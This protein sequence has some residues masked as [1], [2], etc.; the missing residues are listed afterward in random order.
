MRTPEFI[1]RCMDAGIP[2]DM[3]LTAAKAFEAECE[4]AVGEVMEARRAK[5]RARQAKHRAKTNECNVVSRDQTLS[6]VSERDLTGE[7]TQVVTPSL[8]SL[9][10]EVQEELKTPISPDGEMR[11]KAQPVS[12]FAKP[13][14]FAQFW[15]AYP[16]KVG[17]P[18]A[19]KAYAKALK[20][21]PGPDPPAVLL[22]AIG[23]ARTSRKWLDGII[24]NPSTWLNQDR[25][26][27]EPA[28]VISL[29]GQPHERPDNDPKF[30][31]RQA[32][33]AASDAGFDAAAG[34]SWK[35]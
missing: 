16:S 3:A 2:L 28:E 5:E 20:R 30:N 7:R 10:S 29:H 18:V 33:Y 25:W 14:G 32:N 8:P 4:L 31:R 34:R 11:P 26:L 6:S 9:P 1:K 15:E 19:E 27:D 12:R 24:P 23:R 35:P 22:A 21:I 17:K 13:N